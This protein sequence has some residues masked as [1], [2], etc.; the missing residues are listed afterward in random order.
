MLG[1]AHPKQYI[2]T[3]VVLLP[4]FLP[5]KTYFPM[6]KKIDVQQWYDRGQHTSRNGMYLEGWKCLMVPQMP[7]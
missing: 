5:L 6:A 1:R 7:H 3:L 4:S 2:N